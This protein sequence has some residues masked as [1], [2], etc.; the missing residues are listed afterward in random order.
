MYGIPAQYQRP[1]GIGAIIVILVI[2]LL[3]A[4][5]N[6]K[7]RKIFDDIFGSDEGADKVKVNDS[8]LRAGFNAKNQAVA[9]ATYFSNAYDGGGEDVKA[10]DILLE[11]SDDEVKAVHNA[12][13][14]HYKGGK[15][16]SG[17]K[18][19][20]RKQVNAEVIAIW[21]SDAKDKKKRVLARLD[22]L[23]L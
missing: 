11:M 15:F 6:E 13:V 5:K 22:K 19:T 8:N 18:D 20:L 17:I 4:K 21:R 9:L 23:N 1:L 7:L 10:L 12:W 16:W 2:I 3:I 14:E